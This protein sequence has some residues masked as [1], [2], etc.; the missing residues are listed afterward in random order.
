M[1]RWE[2]NFKMD[3]REIGV[4]MRNR[5]DLPQDRNYWRAL[6]DAVLNLQVS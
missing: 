1:H 5:V 2:D 3:L 6:V 4:N